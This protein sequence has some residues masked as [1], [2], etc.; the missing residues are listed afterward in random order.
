MDDF[1]SC[2]SQIWVTP[3]AFGQIV[4]TP[5]EFG[6]IWTTPRILKIKFQFIKEYV[7]IFN[8]FLFMK[9]FKYIQFSETYD[10]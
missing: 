2:T 10:E 5:L 8:I 1:G 6:K 3:V 9:T 7:F 4:A